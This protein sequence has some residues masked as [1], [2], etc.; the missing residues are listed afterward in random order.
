MAAEIFTAISALRM[1]LDSETDADSPDN[2]T[3]FAAIRVAIESLFLILLG[4]GV[5]GTVTG[6]AE[7]VLTDTD[8]FTAINVHAEHTLLMTSGAAKGNMYTI[9][10]NTVD[11]LTCTGDDM[12]GNGVAIGDYYVILYD[13]K[14]STGHTHDAKNARNIDLAADSVLVNHL[15]PAAVNTTAMKTTVGNTSGNLASGTAVAVAMQDYCFFPSL[16]ANGT[17]GEM[18]LTTAATS[19]ATYTGRFG[20][21]NTH[22]SSA[23]DWTAYW[24]YITASDEPFVYAIRDIS[25]GQIIATWVCEDPPPGYWGLDEKPDDFEPPIIHTPA[26]TGVEEIVLFKY[27]KDA[28]DELMQKPTKDKVFLHELIGADYDY[29]S[30]KKLF[31]TKNLAT[32]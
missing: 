22:V 6:I 11:A 2:E 32:I 1:V 25:T 3:T 14:T 5:T 16:Y 8:N 27:P 9:D 7:E 21:Y 10:S 20:I 30:G 24:R 19:G 29:D 31:V 12:S 28:F 4:T 17:L 18:H 15:G 23:R 13:C 26:L